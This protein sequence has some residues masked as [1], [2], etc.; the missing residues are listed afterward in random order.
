MIISKEREKMGTDIKVSVICCAYNQEQYI[1]DALKG[2]VSQKTDFDFEVLISDDAS[3]DQTPDIIRRYEKEYPELI[4]PLYLTENQYSKGI[5]PGVLLMEKAQGQYYALCEGDDYWTSDHKLQRQFDALEM[6]P[7]CDMCAHSALKVRPHDCKPIGMIEPM[8]EDGILSMEK[9]IDGG[10]DFIATNS[11]FF[12]KSIVQNP[13]SYTRLY[14]IDY[15]YQMGGAARGGIVYLQETMSAYRRGADNS[16]TVLMMNS[17]KDLR[18]NYINK[19]IKM[20]DLVNEETEYKYQDSIQHA[21]L[22]YEF[23]KDTLNRDIRSV[24]SK[25]YSDL[26]DQMSSKRKTILFLQCFAPWS[27]RLYQKTKKVKSS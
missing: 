3:T 6:H 27:L 22:K 15:A 18:I 10:G 20:L 4:K 26:R 5:Y 1:E 16:W 7:E 13:A 24:Y 11:L 25:K 17:Q 19:M 2:F 23:Q 21:Q 9:V 8:K 12:R 14:A